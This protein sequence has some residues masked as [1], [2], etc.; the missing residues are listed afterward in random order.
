[1]KIILLKDIPKLGKYLDIK[2][3]KPGY[4]RN[5]LIPQ[6]MAI[7]ATSESLKWR[8]KQLE[9][10]QKIQKENIEKLRK[11][12]EQLKKMILEIPVKV[13]PKG[14]LFE[15]IDE[16]KIA[17]F[18]QKNNFDI[19]KENIKIRKNISK[20]GDHSAEIILGNDIVLNL[21]I[22]IKEEKNKKESKKKK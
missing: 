9:N 3:V 8:E 6:K 15:K 12:A 7:L 14:K 20:V 21:K 17:K 19:Q 1:M 18:L 10:Q 2:R 13:G 11:M 4:G 22:K 16:G 5:F